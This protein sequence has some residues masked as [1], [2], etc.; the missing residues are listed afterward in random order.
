[1][2]PDHFELEYAQIQWLFNS[3]IL[4]DA[5]LTD[6][7]GRQYLAKFFMII[8]F[9]DTIMDF[10]KKSGHPINERRLL[11]IIGKLFDFDAFKDR[12][13]KQHIA[14]FLFECNLF[15]SIKKSR[16]IQNCLSLSLN[17]S[18][19]DTFTKKIISILKN[20]WKNAKTPGF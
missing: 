11:Y 19:S 5:G 8:K 9:D 17:D 10:I 3:N 15:K 12:V 2:P 14:D 20:H 4:V 16:S 18:L 6:M 13:T 1:M 7:T